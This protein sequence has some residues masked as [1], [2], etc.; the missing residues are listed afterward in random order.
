MLCELLLDGGAGSVDGLRVCDL[1]FIFAKSGLVFSFGIIVGGSVIASPNAQETEDNERYAE[2]CY[3]RYGDKTDNEANHAA[4]PCAVACGFVFFVYIVGFLGFR[5][6]RGV[7]IQIS[8]LSVN[9]RF[10]GFNIPVE[11]GAEHFN[12]AYIA[13]VGDQN[14]AVIVCHASSLLSVF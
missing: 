13:Q 10:A 12:A 11:L 14:L 5:G 1:T 6:K 9:F 3:V 2:D 8:V 4:Y 7:L